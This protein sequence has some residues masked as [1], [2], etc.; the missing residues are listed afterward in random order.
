MGNGIGGE[1]SHDNGDGHESSAVATVTSTVTSTMRHAD[2]YCWNSETHNKD[3]AVGVCDQVP[4][5]TPGVLAYSYGMLHDWT[6]FLTNIATA[7]PIIEQ[8]ITPCN[9]ALLHGTFALGSRPAVALV[10]QHKFVQATRSSATQTLT[11]IHMHEGF[12]NHGK[13]LGSC[14]APVPK[15]GELVSGGWPMLELDA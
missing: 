11:F 1:S 8:W 5:S 10:P 13:D 3:A 2:A 6:R 9:N 12:P 7:G 15:Q 4:T 14:G